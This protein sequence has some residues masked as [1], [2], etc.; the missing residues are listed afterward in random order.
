MTRHTAA[1]AQPRARHMN[2][3][4]EYFDLVAS[5]RKKIEVCVQYANLRNLTGGQHIKF[6]CGHDECLVRVARYS[7]FEDMLDSEGPAN[8]SPYSPR[9]QQLTNIRR[10][11]GPEK[12]SPGRSRHRDRTRYGLTRTQRGALSPALQ[13]PRSRFGARQLAPA[14]TTTSSEHA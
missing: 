3:Y 13:M 5:G 10:I 1:P 4:C 11:Y 9:E 12:E 14:T 6:A 7:S 2:L 8:V